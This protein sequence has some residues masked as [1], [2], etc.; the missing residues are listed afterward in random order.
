MIKGNIIL[1]AGPSGSGKDTVMAKL[2]ERQKDLCFSIS[3]T[4]RPMREGEVQ[5]LKYHH[6][7][8]EKF[9]ELLKN[10]E[11]L[12]YNFYAGNYYGTAKTPVLECI[13]K[14]KDML[15]EVDVNGAKNI[16]EILPDAITVFIMPPSFEVLKHR[17]TSRGTE[18]PEQIEKRLN[19]ALDEI[20]RANEFDY[21]VVNDD[22]IGAVDDFERIILTERLKYKNN[23]ELVERVLK[24]C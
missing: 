5:D 21:I 24:Q 2:F 20:R 19:T 9:D 1:L 7:S 23:K 14:G 10:D 6:I 12:E 3:H 15:I 11:F 17:L 8:K 13:E 16:K 18:K 4:T 22:L